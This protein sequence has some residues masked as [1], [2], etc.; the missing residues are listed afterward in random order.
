MRND[1]VV[2]VVVIRSIGK[3]FTI[4]MTT[5]NE[6]FARKLQQKENFTNEIGYKIIKL[7]I[8]RVG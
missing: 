2:V 7:N 4:S 5:R 8:I 6:N 3:C 1:V